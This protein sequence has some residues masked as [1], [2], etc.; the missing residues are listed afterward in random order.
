MTSIHLSKRRGAR[1]ISFIEADHANPISN[2]VGL[3]ILAVPLA[4][5][6][7]VRPAWTARYT[8]SDFGTNQ[9]VALALDKEGNVLVSGHGTSINGD[10]DYL[11]LK[12][13]PTG[14]RLWASRYASPTNDQVRSM[15]ADKDGNAYITGTS[16][17]VKYGADGSEQWTASYAARGLAL[18]PHGDAYV[19]GFS[20]TTYATAKVHKDAGTNLWLRSYSYLGRPG[21]PDI[22]QVIAVD[23]KSNVFV[24]GQVYCHVGRPIETYVNRLAIS[25]DGDGNQRW[26]SSPFPDGCLNYQINSRGIGVDSGGNV[27]VTGNIYGAGETYSTVKHSVAGSPLW[28]YYLDPSNFE[29]VQSLVVG[30]DGSIILTGSSGSYATVKL[31][32]GGLEDWVARYGNTAYG[33]H[34]ANAIALDTAGNVYVT[35]QSPGPGTGND[36]AT[37]KYSPDGQELWVQRYDGPA[38]GD[39]VATAIAVAPDGSVYVTGWST[40]SSNLIE[41]TTIKYTQS[42]GL[43]LD[44]N[45]NAQLQFLGAP[46][47]SNRVQATVDFLDWLDL[48]FSVGDTNG[49]LRFLDTNAPSHPFRFYRMVP[50]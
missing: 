4:L 28:K 20:S 15:A 27:Y 26:V 1:Y 21:Y 8:L 11:A 31:T 40:T 23:S 39:D 17:T 22:S 3:L 34:F 47:S 50:P 12:Y 7:G 43:S 19:T 35:G 48:G 42:P 6:A 36:Y 2:L 44:T 25:Y 5:P 41:I 13:S 46:G 30:Q 45:R 16:V 33:Y 9:A 10:F 49:C 24:G 14:T 32:T 29:G 18:D 37:I 38:H